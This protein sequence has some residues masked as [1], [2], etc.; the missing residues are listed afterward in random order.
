MKSGGGGKRES[1]TA[2]HIEIVWAKSGSFQ[3]GRKTT[4]GGGRE[5]GL[6]GGKKRQPTSR[7]AL[8]DRSERG[9]WSE[10]GQSLQSQLCR[11]CGE[12]EKSGK[13]EDRD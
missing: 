3:W 7:R 12:E 13:A 5:G 11:G 10:G 8:A 6:V 9:G 1:G 2:E 4:E